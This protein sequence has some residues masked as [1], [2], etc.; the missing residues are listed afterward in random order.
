MVLARSPATHKPLAMSALDASRDIVASTSSASSS[1][2]PTP[3]AGVTP[4][5]LIANLSLVRYEPV[6][7]EPVSD[8]ET[9]NSEKLEQLNH[10]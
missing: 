9:E 5:T 6:R 4:S 8:S 7:Y 2:P 1:D 3:S 10:L